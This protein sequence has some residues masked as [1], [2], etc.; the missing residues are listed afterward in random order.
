MNE[1]KCISCV[2]SHGDFYIPAMIIIFCQEKLTLE[3]KSSKS[4]SLAIRRLD[5][6][7][8]RAN[9]GEAGWNAAAYL[10]ADI[11]TVA[12][13]VEAKGDMVVGRYQEVMRKSVK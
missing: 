5:D 10:S 7:A 9:V 1:I 11:A 3:E 8:R 13:I 6:M 2:F 12:I 4:L